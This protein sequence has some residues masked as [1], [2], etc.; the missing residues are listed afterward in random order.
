MAGLL[1]R[2][3]VNRASLWLLVDGKST[4]PKRVPLSSYCDRIGLRSEVHTSFLVENHLS[5][6]AGRKEFCLSFDYDPAP[7]SSVQFEPTCIIS[8]GIEYC[9]I[10]VVE[11]LSEVFERLTSD[12]VTGATYTSGFCD[13]GTPIETGRGHLYGSVIPGYV[14]FSRLVD[15]LHWLNSGPAR[16]QGKLRGVFWG[17]VLPAH[18]ARRLGDEKQFVAEYSALEDPQNRNL[19]HVFAEGDI[20]IWLTKSPVPFCNHSIL[21]TPPVYERAAW[22]KQ[23]FL[24]AGLL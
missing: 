19:T 14:A 4:V 13:I 1:R 17:Q 18:L 24:E 5:R 9:P 11:T 10:E 15:R 20:V 8:I 12:L 2:L 3:S 7:V 6:Q 22:L 16:R 21:I 23:R